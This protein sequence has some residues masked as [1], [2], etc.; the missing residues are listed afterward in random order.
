M[1]RTED[2]RERVKLGNVFGGGNRN[3]NKIITFEIAHSAPRSKVARVGAEESTHFLIKMYIYAEPCTRHTLCGTIGP[4]GRLHKSTL[5]AE[6][7]RR[8]HFAHGAHHSHL[9]YLFGSCEK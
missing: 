3:A 8:R 5:Y 9:P 2:D 7:R 1:T 6:R 4:V